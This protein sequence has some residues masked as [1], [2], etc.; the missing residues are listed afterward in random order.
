MMNNSWRDVDGHSDTQG[1]MGGKK[2]Q[3]KSRFS[4][5]FVPFPPFFF[6]LSKSHCAL[7]AARCQINDAG[8]RARSRDTEPVWRYN[9]IYNLVDSCH[10]SLAAAACRRPTP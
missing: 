2:T 3:Q 7:P 1:T 6:C 10:G 5:F 4:V 9:P 8:A